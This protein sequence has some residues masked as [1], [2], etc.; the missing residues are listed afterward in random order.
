MDCVLI[1]SR[2]GLDPITPD[3]DKPGCKPSWSE[4]LKVCYCFYSLADTPSHDTLQHCHAQYIIKQLVDTPSHDALQYCHPQ[5]II[6]Q[7]FSGF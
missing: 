6:N 2:K 1:L 7:Y 5:N 3:L 4:S